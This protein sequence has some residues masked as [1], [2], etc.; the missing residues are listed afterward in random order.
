MRGFGWQA[1]ARGRRP[2]A[3]QQLPGRRPRAPGVARRIL[4]AARG[5]LRGSLAALAGVLCLSGAAAAAPAPQPLVVLAASSLT[6]VLNELGPRYTRRTRQEVKLSYGASSTLAREIEAGAP[7]DV[8]LSADT[9]WMDYLQ[10][11][12]LIARGTRRNVAAN[13]LVLIAPAASTAHLRIAPHFALLAALAGGRLA[14]GDPD[15]VPAGR[16]AKAALSALGVWTAVQDHIAAAEN[17]RVAL[18]YVA[19]GETPLGI[20]YRT[21]ALIDRQ[22][23]IVDTFPAGS[24][25]P[26]V[27]PGAATAQARAGA[28]DF[29]RFLLRPAA[30]AVFRKYGFTAPP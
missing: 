28:G 6:D 27:Y 26:I 1:V 9:D 19:R 29:I 30:Q 23:R 20:V 17:V 16:Y 8:M 10:K 24:H 21:D 14:T 7:A 4:A 22:V 13:A 12:S 3:W 2:C 18:A 5:C 11:R 15:S 25:P